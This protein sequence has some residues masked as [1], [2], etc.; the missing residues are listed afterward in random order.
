MAGLKWSF[1]VLMCLTLFCV[2]CAP[3]LYTVSVTHNGKP[4]GGAVVWYE[5][6]YMSQ[7]CYRVTDYGYGRT[8]A[9]GKFHLLAHGSRLSAAAVYGTN[10][11]GYT[12]TEYN[13][14]TCVIKIGGVVLPIKELQPKDWEIFATAKTNSLGKFFFVPFVGPEKGKDQKAVCK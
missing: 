9:G 3:I 8:D 7:F 12:S 1:R 6:S 2:G 5:A 13:R 4:M 11:W 14:P 10:L